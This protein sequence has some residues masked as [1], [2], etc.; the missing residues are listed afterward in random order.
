MSAAARLQD[1]CVSVLGRTAASGAALLGGA[2]LSV[3]IFH[4]VLRE[5]DPIFPGELDAR[6]FE[7]LMSIVART[8]RVLPL[9][10]AVRL[11]QA[12]RLPPRA[13]AITFD[14][15]YADNHDVAMPILNRLGLSATV[16]IATAFLDGGRMWNDT[17][18]ECL[19]GTQLDT[20]DLTELG[21]SPMP[22]RSASDRRRAIE[23]VIPVVKYQVPEGREPMLERLH[24]LC[25]RPVLPSNLMMRSTD[26]R[27]LQQGGL[28]V[29]AHTVNHPILRTLPDDQ[30]QSEMSASKHQL[31]A[32]IDEPV[33]L[34]AYPNGQPGVDFDD[35]HMAMARQLGYTAALSTR[36]G[37]ARA[38]SD[39]YCL[40][41]YTPWEPDPL[42]WAGR[43][44]WHHV[45]A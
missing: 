2:R 35:R 31:Q 28:G 6:R 4:R 32:L 42:R 44:A 33:T 29:G 23:R 8:F 27:S 26:V 1:T 12:R 11:L 18:I 25:G 39:V 9:D 16:F 36:K 7:R 21:L 45:N 20:V 34:F 41:R 5:P 40:P 37:V 15:G 30:A 43:L 17:V 38:G 14:D 13:L 10:E 22:T 24:S 3:L 19:R